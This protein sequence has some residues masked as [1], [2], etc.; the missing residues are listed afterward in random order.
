[1]QGTSL[2]MVCDAM[3]YSS[4]RVTKRYVKPFEDKK[5]NEMN[6]FLISYVKQVAMTKMQ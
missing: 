4:T 6:D 5:I 2:D 1:M 3:G